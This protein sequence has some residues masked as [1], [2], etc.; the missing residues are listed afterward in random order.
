MY[1]KGVF[2][3]LRCLLIYI[4]ILH[5]L[6]L[7]MAI[8]LTVWEYELHWTTIT[9]MYPSPWSMGYHEWYPFIF[10]QECCI[11]L[12]NFVV[13]STSHIFL[14]EKK[15]PIVTGLI[16]DL[17]LILNYFSNPKSNILLLNVNALWTWF[18]CSLAANGEVTDTPLTGFAYL[19]DLSL[20]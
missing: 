16:Q 5:A 15:I 2:Y 10:S 6:Y 18:E 1:H 8:L 11:H 7:L 14:R 12:V 9:T 17:Y 4:I 3:L 19:Y 20:L 13:P